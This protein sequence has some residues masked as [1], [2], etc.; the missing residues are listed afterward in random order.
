MEIRKPEWE[1]LFYRIQS[2]FFCFIAI[3]FRIF[4]I[5]YY[6]FCR[7]NKE[8]EYTL[9]FNT[10]G[11]YNVNYTFKNM[12]DLNNQEKSFTECKNYFLDQVRKQY[13]RKWK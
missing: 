10:Y 7:S 2:K 11:K 1:K 5:E 9:V 3:K 12:I 6:G 4:N 13:Y 8:K